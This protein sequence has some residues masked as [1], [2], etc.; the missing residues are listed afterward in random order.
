ME[1]EVQDGRDV[2]HV[3][4]QLVDPAECQGPEHAR[5]FAGVLAHISRQSPSQ[6]KNLMI[7]DAME[8]LE[9][10]RFCA[11]CWPA[12]DRVVHELIQTPGW[13]Q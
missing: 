7:R 13:L 8:R 11:A 3:R 12:I 1:I 9:Q 10:A 4:L 6:M 2:L 5:V